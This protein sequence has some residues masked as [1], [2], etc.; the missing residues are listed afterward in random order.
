MTV[1]KRKRE[2]AAEIG[3]RKLFDNGLTKKR[4]ILS[5]LSYLHP[6]Q[7]NHRHQEPVNPLN[8]LQTKS[9]HLNEILPEVVIALKIF[10][11]IPVSV[12]RRERSFS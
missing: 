12:A 9:L 10:F 4:T 5:E 11:T 2:E 8:V 7:M 3:A 1:K 6:D